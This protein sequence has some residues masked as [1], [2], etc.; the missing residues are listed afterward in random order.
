MEGGR[1]TEKEERPIHL[2]LYPMTQHTPPC[3]KDRGEETHSIP[4]QLPNL[5]HISQ[6]RHRRQRQMIPL[7]TLDRFALRLMMD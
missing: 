1:V 3:S 6:A 5:R 4:K 7:S 2:L